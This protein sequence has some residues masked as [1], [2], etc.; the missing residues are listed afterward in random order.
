VPFVVSDPVNDPNFD[1]TEEEVLDYIQKASWLEYNPENDTV[2]R[3]AGQE[4]N[5]IHSSK[6]DGEKE[7]IVGKVN[8]SK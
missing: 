2:T 5:L 8:T 1:F 6:V 3:T 7:A 4:E